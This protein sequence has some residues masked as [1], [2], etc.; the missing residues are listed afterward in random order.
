M[1]LIRLADGIIDPAKLRT[2]HTKKSAAPR[3][4]FFCLEL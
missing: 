4:L 1:V 3:G 2:K